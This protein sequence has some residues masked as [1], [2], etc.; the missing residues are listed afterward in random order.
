MAR[1]LSMSFLQSG[2]KILSMDDWKLSGTYSQASTGDMGSKKI[3]SK[4]SM[5][6][7]KIMDSKNVL[8][9]VYTT[10]LVIIRAESFNWQ[11][12]SDYTFQNGLSNKRL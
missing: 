10:L 6:S 12:S 7:K 2:M 1:A 9:L 11:Q 3:C 8:V 4:K 5:G